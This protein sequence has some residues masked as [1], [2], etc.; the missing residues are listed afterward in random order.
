MLRPIPPLAVLFAIA[1]SVGN[2]WGQIAAPPRVGSQQSLWNAALRPNTSEPNKPVAMTNNIIKPTPLSAESQRSALNNIDRH[3][4]SQIGDLSEKLKTILPDE[5]AILTTT[6]GWKTEDQQALVGALR[7]GDPTA[8]YETWVKG[9]PQDTAGAELAARQTDVK[10]LMTRLMQDAEKNKAALRQDVAEFDA[11][12]GKIAG[13]TPAVSDLAAPVKTLKTWVEA[14]NLIE[15]ATPGKGAV[16]KL[17]TGGDVTLIFDPTLP[18][19][20]AL[21]LSDHAMLIGYEGHSSLVIARGNA[22]EALGLPIV[23][24]TPLAEA[25][26]EEVS[27][28][29]LIINPAGSRGTI[30]YNI[31]GNH[32]VA[33]PGMQQKLAALPEGRGWIIEYDRGERFGPVAYTLSPGT[34]YF[35]PTDLGWQ[36]YRHRFEIVL[37]NSQSNQEFNFIF[38]GQDL[39][40]PAG[41]ART[42]SSNYPIVVRFDRGNSSEFVAKSTPLTVGNLQVGVNATDNLWDLFPTSDNRREL[43]N[44]KPFNADELRRR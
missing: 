43:T 14:R 3:V 8:V 25:E 38:H 15:T 7:A 20:T 40:V 28:G 17:P 23:T 39:M 4:A 26:G 29:V 22:A 2:A 32:Y 10:R 35:T 1:V 31:N 13:S 44:L 42:L 16:A 6:T 36:L 18:L 5:L 21:V 37:D 19:G 41:G 24:G 34:Y 33:Q 27:D 12:L 9:N 11:A 30:N